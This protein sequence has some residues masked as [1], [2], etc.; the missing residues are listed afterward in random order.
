LIYLPVANGRAHLVVIR[1]FTDHA[2]NERT[3]LAWIRTAVALMGLGFVVERFDLFV[4]YL[5][6]NGSAARPVDP[7][8]RPAGLALIAFGVLVLTV[9]TVRY[10]TFKRLIASSEAREFG[11]SRTDLVLVAVVGVLGVMMA[12][13]LL[14]DVLG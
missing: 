9:S 5:G 3:Y 8:V 14:R 11:S 2:A 6:A 1:S 12:A 10:L 7:W 4:Q 13:Y